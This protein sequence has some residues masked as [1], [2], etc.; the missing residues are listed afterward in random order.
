MRHG[1][2]LLRVAQRLKRLVKE[3][4]QVLLLARWELL[5]GARCYSRSHFT[6]R[7]LCLVYQSRQAEDLDHS[8][9]SAWSSRVPPDVIASLW[10]GRAM[11]YKHSS[12]T[13][14]RYF[15]GERESNNAY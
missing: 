14:M 3:D 2:G 11:T 12:Q 4:K 6:L 9:K 7:A 13:N 15:G 8:K 1:Q 5:S 10:T